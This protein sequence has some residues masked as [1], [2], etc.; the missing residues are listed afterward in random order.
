MPTGKADVKWY[1]RDASFNASSAPNY[2]GTRYHRA[3]AA[4]DLTALCT[5]NLA[6]RGCILLDERL[7]EEDPLARA[8]REL[9][10]APCHGRR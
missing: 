2:R 7:E 3:K 5:T 10:E 9:P 6:V 4:D 1:R 8:L